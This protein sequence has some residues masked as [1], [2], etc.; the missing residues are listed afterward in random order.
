L[1]AV[2]ASLRMLARVK[3]LNKYI[4]RQFS[5]QFRIR[6]GLHYGSVIIGEVG[7]RS[8]KQLTVI[9]DTVNVASR[10]E[11]VNKEF[12]TQILASQ[13]MLDY[14]HNEVETAQVFTT[15]FRGQNRSH[16]LYEI[17]GFKQPD[18]IFLIQSTL[19]KITPHLDD[20]TKSFYE[21]L[22]AFEPS[23]KSLFSTPNA[24][25][26]M[27]INMIGLVVQGINRFDLIVPSVQYI[28]EKHLGNHVKPEYY[29][30]AGKT[31]VHV[32]EKYL[33]KDFTPEVKHLWI[34][35]YEQIVLL[36]KSQCQ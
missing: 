22:F 17:V 28:N 27:V 2:R 35:F 8:N 20:V 3:E 12:G 23:L 21:Q 1:N 16:K 13:E 25:K 10:I 36:V 30:I 14:I 4:S 29:L 5:H 32:L 33:G 15:Q 34:K 7:Y 6:I 31:L 19:E 24:K 26:Q 11:S 18:T 9:G